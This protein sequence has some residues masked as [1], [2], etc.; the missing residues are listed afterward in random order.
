[1]HADVDTKT[2]MQNYLE[3][4]KETYAAFYHF[5]HT[6]PFQR[7]SPIVSKSIKCRLKTSR[8]PFWCSHSFRQWS[9]SFRM[10]FQDVKTNAPALPNHLFWHQKWL[11][12]SGLLPQETNIENPW[13]ER[14]GQQARRDVPYPVSRYLLHM[15]HPGVSAHLDPCMLDIWC[16]LIEIKVMFDNS[17]FTTSGTIHSAIPMHAFFIPRVHAAELM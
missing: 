8:R 1:M 3:R 4:N 14:K 5:V 7:S 6:Q 11:P 13:L 9:R 16:L 2:G 10:V 15:L 17:W 12:Y